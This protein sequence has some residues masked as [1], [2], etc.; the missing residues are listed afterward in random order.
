M[1]L[2]SHPD[3]LQQPRRGYI[4]RITRGSHPVE[5]QVSKKILQ[6]SAHG[7]GSVSLP[8]MGVGESEADSGAAWFL[9]EH[10]ESTVTNQAGLASA[11]HRNLIPV[12]RLPSHRML[13]LLQ[14]GGSL[15]LRVRR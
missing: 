13:H 9:G 11:F 2:A 5:R 4:F 7:F 8:L 1:R 10:L 14:E 6:Q 12:P 15:L 3:A